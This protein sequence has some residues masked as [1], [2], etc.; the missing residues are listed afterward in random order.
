MAEIDVVAEVGLDILYRGIHL[1]PILFVLLFVIVFGGLL[2]F[3][4]LFFLFHKF[5]LNL[6][7]LARIMQ[8]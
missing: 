1:A 5:A 4:F 2:P 3:L 6:M 7:S 8:R